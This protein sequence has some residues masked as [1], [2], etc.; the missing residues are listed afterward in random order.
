MLKLVVFGNQREQTYLFLISMNSIQFNSIY[1]YS[2]FNN[3]IVSRC[4][5]ALLTLTQSQNPQVSTVAFYK[6]KP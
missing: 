5:T 2:V 3:N 1:L 6:K 4:F